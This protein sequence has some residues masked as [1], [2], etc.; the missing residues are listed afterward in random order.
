MAN[1]LTNAV[2]P[3]MVGSKPNG[4]QSYAKRVFMFA[5]VA[6]AVICL[7]FVVA[8]HK[9]NKNSDALGGAY[10]AVTK[11]PAFNFNREFDFLP[12]LSIEIFQYES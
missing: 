5:S 2:A 8:H 7:G 12:S 11:P 6:A 3:V 4:G 9:A 1:G 10:Y